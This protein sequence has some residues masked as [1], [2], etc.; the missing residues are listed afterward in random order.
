MQLPVVY[1]RPILVCRPMSVFEAIGECPVPTWCRCS[2]QLP[3]KWVTGGP[4]PEVEEGT[5]LSRGL[6]PKW[7]EKV[8]VPVMEE[9]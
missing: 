1:D 8:S 7:A 3:H 9:N 6:S 5:E 2:R 4:I